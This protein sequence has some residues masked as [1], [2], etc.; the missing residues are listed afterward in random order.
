[1]TRRTSFLILGAGPFGLSMAAYARSLQI[2][3]LVVG[4]PMA[5]WKSNMPKG[6]ILRS[7]CDWHLDPLNVHTIEHYLATQ[8]LTPADVEPL[9]LAFYL[10]YA[11]WFQEQKQIE[12]LPVFVHRLDYVNG[13]N[14]GA[15]HFEAV[16]ADGDVIH[17]DNVLLAVGFRYFTH[18]PDEA[19]AL[20]PS[21][22][23]SHTCDLADFA[24]LKGKRCL[25]L[26][27]RQS[28]FEWAAL[29]LE[30]G[31]AA[32]HVVHRHATPLFTPSN[33]TWVPPLV[34][35][36]VDNPS[37]YRRL[38]PDQKHEIG[39]R[40][41]GEGRLK[42][43]PWLGPRIDDE[44]VQ[45]WP[46]SHIVA[47]DEL[48]GG[49]LAV[50]LDTGP[51]LLVDHVIAATG[52]KVNVEQVPFLVNGNILPLLTTQNGYPVLNEYFQTSV[53]GLFATSMMA[54][55]DFGP[56]FAFT[57]SVRAAARIIGAGLQERLKSLKG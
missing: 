19:A 26:G 25:I 52:Y 22:R 36:M 3:H 20:I 43:E 13:K 32:I 53:P 17:A 55:Q 40:L 34:D 41:W 50:K 33:W 51:T 5:F 4:E 57:V 48:P 54:V 14:G 24:P 56:F 30:E 9:S 47:C 7:A 8:K 31:A 45:L 35:A 2:D 29:L 16:L 10:G 23:L 18:V 39:Q 28:A 37:W 46:H 44:A 21:G 6:M 42:L 15:P 38:S 12:A 49:E 27:G 1:M 11:Q